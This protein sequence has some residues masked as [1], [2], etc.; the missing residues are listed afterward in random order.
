[1]LGDVLND[2]KNKTLGREP[3][4][5][6]LRR[7]FRRVTSVPTDAP[8]DYYESIVIYNSGATY[9]LYVYDEVSGSWRYASLT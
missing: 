9:R 7:G 6:D 5:D 4:T 3:R 8:K 1:M 2:P